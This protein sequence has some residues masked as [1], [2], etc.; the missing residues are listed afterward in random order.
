LLRASG[1]PGIVQ[2]LIP[3]KKKKTKR[4]GAAFS[5]MTG[6]DPPSVTASL[7]IFALD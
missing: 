5:D 2:R 1:K 3:P 7:P 6:G 4:L